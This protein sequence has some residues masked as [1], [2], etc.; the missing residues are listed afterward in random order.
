MNLVITFG[1]VMNQQDKKKKR[2]LLVASFGGHWI[3]LRSIEKAFEDYEIIYLTTEKSCKSQVPGKDFYNVIDAA[4]DKKVKLILLA[5]E[6]FWIIL[7]VRP[8]VVVST[9][10]APG[11]FALMF[12][13]LLGAKTIWVDSIANA[14]KM[15][16]SG[17]KVK[18]F[19][20]LWLTQWQ[21]I[22]H[23]N[24]PFYMGNVL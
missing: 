12:G 1:Y 8:H 6:V 20:D 4:L 9:G 22:A 19:A 24:G 5:L 10:A 14:E 7:K 13:K 3:Q 21:H 18:P 11:F 23:E 16:V 2:A 15:S 17:K